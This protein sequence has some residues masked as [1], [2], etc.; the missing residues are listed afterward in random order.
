MPWRS[1]L[2][3]SIRKTTGYV[4][5]PPTAGEFF[6]LTQSST[7]QFGRAKIVQILSNGVRWGEQGF[8]AENGEF[9]FQY[10][11][12]GYNRSLAVQGRTIKLLNRPWVIELFE[13]VSEDEFGII[14]LNYVGKQNFLIRS[15]DGKN[16]TTNSEISTLVDT[17]FYFR[18][19]L[20]KSSFSVSAFYSP[21]ND[22]LS[23]PSIA[24]WEQGFL[25]VFTGL[26]ASVLQY[27]KAVIHKL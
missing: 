10:A 11:F 17:T 2:K 24:D 15:L 25:A 1:L 26:N 8:S 22:R 6:K 21:N 3:L 23:F 14:E 19:N 20:P 12:P 13:F 4:S 27:V 9:S 16:I 18:V 7:P 5:T